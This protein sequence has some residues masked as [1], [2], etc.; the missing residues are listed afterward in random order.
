MT[1]PG[2][3]PAGAFRALHHGR[4]A[5]DPLVLP[6]VWD[7]ASAAVFAE[8]GYAGLAT[9][10]SAVAA[11][12]GFADGGHTPPDEM[13]AAVARIARAETLYLATSSV[14]SLRLPG[15]WPCPAPP[16]PREPA[17]GR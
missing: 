5:G 3:T 9:S 1:Q 7:A 12:L 2:A 15:P 8:A 10:S 14:P 17:T 13:F 4:D 6:N 16:R 11:T